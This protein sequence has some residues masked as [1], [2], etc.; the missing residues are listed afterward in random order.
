MVG[1]Q[2]LYTQI[3]LPYTTRSTPVARAASSTAAVALAFSRSAPAG[4]ACTCP[5]S[6]IAARWITAMQPSMAR[7]SAGVSVASPITVSTDPGSWCG[8]S[9]RSKMRG[10]YPR[11]ASVS[12]TWEPMKPEPPVTSTLERL[13]V[14]RTD[15][16]HLARVARPDVH[17]PVRHDRRAG[18]AGGADRP[19]PG[20]REAAIASHAERDQAP[21]IATVRRVVRRRDVDRAA[22]GVVRGRSEQGR[23]AVVRGGRHLQ[24]LEGPARDPVPPVDEQLA[25]LVERRQLRP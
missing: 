20:D 17:D 9:R 23:F 5:T 24:A 16:A 2:S 4:S 10:S 21:L 8:D 7:A 22:G 12:T 19:L 25:V 11:A 3:V 18:Q 1:S 15:R 14:G 13:A 6:A